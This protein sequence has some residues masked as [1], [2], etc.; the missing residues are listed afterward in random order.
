[1]TTSQSKRVEV[2]PTGNGITRKW[3]WTESGSQMWCEKSSSNSNATVWCCNWIFG[4]QLG[5]IF[6]FHRLSLV[7]RY[8]L[9][10]LL[11]TTLLCI[12]THYYI[13]FF[14]ELFVYSTYYA[15]LFTKLFI[16]DV[17]NCVVFAMKYARNFREK[18]INR[19]HELVIGSHN[20]LTG[21][22]LPGWKSALCWLKFGLAGYD[23]GAPALVLGACAE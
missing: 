2:E 1:M 21:M 15:C 8:Y 20:S 11:L 23:G 10:L 7:I 9:L 19:V 5:S 12:I 17:I 3:Y 22:T 16:S 4:F 13:C 18:K 14:I 6:F